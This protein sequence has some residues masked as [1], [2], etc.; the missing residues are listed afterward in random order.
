M[1]RSRGVALIS[2]L[3][4]L[5]VATTLV[6]G[7]LLTLQLDLRRLETAARLRQARAYALGMESWMRVR[8]QRELRAAGDRRQPALDPALFA[9]LRL[10]IDGGTLE[11]RLVALDGRYNLNNL[12]R[13]DGSIDPVQYALFE[14]LLAL[15]DLPAD[16]APALADWLDADREVR[17]PAGAEDADYALLKPAYGAPDRPL[18]GSSELR[19]VRGLTP[20]VYARLA[21]FVT[22][23][24]APS[25]LDI[26]TAPGL[27]LALMAGGGTMGSGAW[28]EALRP[29]GGF[30][31]VGEFLSRAGAAQNAAP[32]TLMA[33][34]G[35]HFLVIAEARQDD[36]RA[37][38]QSVL[39][40]ED[41]QPSPRVLRRSWSGELE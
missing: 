16:L 26:N 23:L 21:P 11:G 40:R 18:A 20:A 2:V 41:T 35:H 6:S 24:P 3:V 29:P 30:T 10:D 7:L 1:R 32:A 38:L 28:L 5:A 19:G 25:T 12:R 14:R 36:V 4:V 9:P 33:V 8:L 17:F 22:A 34:Q 39:E 31:S 13:A 37:R 15:L 27:L